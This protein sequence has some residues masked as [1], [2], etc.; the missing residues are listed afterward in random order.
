MKKTAKAILVRTLGWQ[1]RRLYRHNTFSTV[2]VVGS[3]GKSSTKRAIARYLNQSVSVQYQDGNYNDIISV[4][5]VFFGLSMPSL[6]NPLAWMITFFLI[7]YELRRPYAYDVVVLELGTDGPGQIRQFA[8][9]LS[10]DIAVITAITPEHMEHFGTIATVAE[11]EFAVTAFSSR[12]I[13]NIDDIDTSYQKQ[14]KAVTYGC[15]KN[16]DIRLIPGVGQAVIHDLQK[17]IKIETPLL[18]QH[19]QKVL[20]AAYAVGKEL[21]ITSKNP[22]EALSRIDAMP[23]RMQFFRGVRS[24]SIIDDTYNASPEAVTAALD[25]LYGIDT[26][27]RIAVLGNM[28]EMGE[29]TQTAHQTVGA[30]CDPKKLDLVIGIGPDAEKYLLP[31]AKKRGNTVLAFTSP[32]EVGGYLQTHIQ[33]N[34]A[35]LVKGSQNGVFLEE[36]VKLILHNPED[37]L[38]LVRQSDAWLAKKQRLFTKKT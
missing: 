31:A 22:A 26:K 33:T 8:D 14:S 6:Y 4:P 10:V 29:F 19:S 38:R 28:N 23:G 2:A 20:A 37:T 11:E 32:Y 25:V 15:G 9:Y 24:S 5:L 3:I 35:V 27:Q 21:G 36:A 7:E 12:V 1:V 16:T 17:T 18:G 34:A 13:M 30:Y